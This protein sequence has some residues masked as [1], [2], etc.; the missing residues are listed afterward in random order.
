MRVPHIGSD[1]KAITEKI[2]APWNASA[3]AVDHRQSPVAKGHSI[4]RPGDAQAM[5]N[6][7]VRFTVRQA[8]NVKTHGNALFQLPHLGRGKS[9]A[10]LWL[11]YEHHLELFAAFR[12]EIGEHAELFKHTWF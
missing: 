10:Q 7:L 4:G 1:Q 9:L 5:R 2:N 6:V 8:L 11:P 3:V 12:L